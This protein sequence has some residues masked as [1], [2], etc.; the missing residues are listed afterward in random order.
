MGGLGSKNTDFPESSRSS[1]FFTH[2]LRKTP[3]K[4]DNRV[5]QISADNAT[6]HGDGPLSVGKDPF[7]NH[8]SVT[9]RTFHPIFLFVKVLDRKR[10]DTKQALCQAQMALD[11]MSRP[12]IGRKVLNLGV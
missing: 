1:F 4:E 8:D 7:F 5:N 10:N 9:S 6:G 2:F 11:F 12:S 3:V